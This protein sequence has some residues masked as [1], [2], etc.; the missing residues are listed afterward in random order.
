EGVPGCVPARGL[1]G[2]WRRDEL[3]PYPVAGLCVDA[4]PVQPLDELP[5]DHKLLG[6]A[7]HSRPPVPWIGSVSL[8]SHSSP[9]QSTAHVDVP[10]ITIQYDPPPRPT[11]VR[12]AAEEVRQ[13][14]GGA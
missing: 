8:A 9:T 4:V 5:V 3:D 14:G 1:R 13:P 2:G 11:M 10:A 6:C 12:S 7:A